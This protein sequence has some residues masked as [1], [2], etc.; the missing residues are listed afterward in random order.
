MFKNT[1]L[2][3]KTKVFA[4]ILTL[5][6]LLIV[7]PFQ[8]RP[9]Q[10]ITIFKTYCFIENKMN[11]YEILWKFMK[12]YENLW[13]IMKYYENL[14][15]IMKFY[16]ILWNF[17]KFYELVWNIM[18]FY[19]I[20]WNFMKF[21]EILWNFMKFYEILWNFMK[22]YEILWKITYTL[23]IQ[24]I[25]FTTRLNSPGTTKPIQTQSGRYVIGPSART[26]L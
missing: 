21:Y 23:M 8:C 7:I 17:M 12:F 14:W 18:K 6:A 5:V 24:Q 3:N 11:C 26:R 2:F 9:L 13:N 1:F 20:L 16:E 4:V 22:F 10:S 25:H 15:N 19:E